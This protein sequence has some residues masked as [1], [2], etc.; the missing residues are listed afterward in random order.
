[1]SY[2]ADEQMACVGVPRDAKPGWSLID[3]PL[4]SQSLPPWLKGMAVEWGDHHDGDPGFILKTD[5]D[6]RHWP[7][8]RYRREGGLWMCES[9]DGR[10]EPFYQGGELRVESLRR[11]RSP[12]GTLSVYARMLDNGR[13]LAPGEWIEVERLCT[14]QEQGFGGAHIDIVMQD[15]T[16][17]TLRGPWHG[18]CPAGFVEVTTVDMSSAYSSGARYRNTPWHQRHGRGCATICAGVFIAAFARYLPHLRLAAVDMGRGDRLQPLKPEWDEPKAW[19][20]AHARMSRKQAQFD[21]MD[22]AERPPH[23]ACNWPK[24]CAGKA[25]CAVAECNHCTKRAA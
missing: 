16:P 13:R 10:A 22:P 14:R 6:L 18:P 21:A 15:G 5:R 1:M 24:A 19:V 2:L 12:D 8:M 7:D 11:W 3:L 17:V 9:D 23:V 25:H 4:G 20:R